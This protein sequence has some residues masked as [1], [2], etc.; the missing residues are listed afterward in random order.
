MMM[1]MMMMMDDDDDGLDLFQ[2][3]AIAETMMCRGWQQGVTKCPVILR[4][5]QDDVAWGSREDRF[6]P[7]ANMRWSPT[8]SCCAASEQCPEKHCIPDR[9]AG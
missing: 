4:N 5:K 2:S 6:W 3:S 1:M 7:A 8:H 9:A